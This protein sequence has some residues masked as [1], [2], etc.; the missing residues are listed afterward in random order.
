MTYHVIWGANEKPGNVHVQVMKTRKTVN[1]RHQQGR[2]RQPMAAQQARGS[3][4]EKI[5]LCH[6]QQGRPVIGGKECH[7]TRLIF[8]CKGFCNVSFR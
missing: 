3:A 4:N 8:A 7:V 2:S 5:V 1:T 6:V